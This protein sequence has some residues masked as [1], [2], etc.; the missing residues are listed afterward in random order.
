M[1]PTGASRWRCP[2]RT[3]SAARA[4]SASCAATRRSICARES[5]PGTVAPA[6]RG[7]ARRGGAHPAA[8]DRAQRGRAR[9]ARG[10]RD[11]GERAA[12][13]RRV[14]RRRHRLAA[15]GHRPPAGAGGTR[16]RPRRRRPARRPARPAHQPGGHPAPGRGGPP[17]R[18]RWV[19]HPARWTSC[20]WSPRASTPEIAVQA[21]L[22]QRTV[23]NVM[24]GLHHATPSAQPCAR[25]G[26]CPAGRLHLTERAIEGGPL[27]PHRHAGLPGRRP[28][29]ACGRTA[30]GA[31]SVTDS[32]GRR[33]RDGRA[34]AQE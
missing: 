5:G 14:R 33:R 18:P 1:S 28:R 22:L 15:R 29:R 32:G 13:R 20:D 24:H 23:K 7:R 34:G 6:H 9:R 30:P 21:V 27:G 25:R 12:G 2:R 4:R 11:P 3:R 17:R 31:R 16:P 26:L 10:R 8:P 19:S